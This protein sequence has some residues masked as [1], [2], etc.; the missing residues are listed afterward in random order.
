MKQ[1]IAILL[2]A[3]S[4]AGA[5]AQS[6]PNKPVRVVVAFTPGSST[7]IIGR[8]VAAKLQEMWGQP[9]VVENRAGAGG[10]VGSEFV[11]R[12][13]A[14]RLHAA[15]Q[16]V[17]ARGEPGHLQGHAL[18]HAE[19]LRQPGAARRRAER[20]DRRPGIGLEDA[21]RLRQRGEGQARQAQF[22]LGRRRQRH[23]FQPREAEDRDRHRRGRTCRT[24]ARPRRSATPSPTA[25]AATGRRST[26]R[27]RTSTAARRWRWRS[28]RR[29]A[30]RCCRTCRASRS[31][32]MPGFDYTLWVGL[33][34]PAKMPADVAAKIN[35]DVNARARQPGP[36]RAPDQARHRAGQPDDSP[37][38]RVREE[39]NRRD[40]PRSC[41][42]PESSPNERKDHETLLRILLAACAL[43]AA[44]PGLSEQAGAA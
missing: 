20:A 31:R 21:A 13:D 37:V 35:K 36:A 3:F 28:R 39:G 4:R 15:R 6:F 43:P 1:L 24:R 34:G 17:G 40:Q 9:V 29:S 14:G 5:L 26:P 25:C 8:A 32:A 44:R 41:R 18:R 27:C 2:A 19:R 11:L 42:P 7:D 30:R 12:S 23:A 22:R 16:F 38:H 33:W 10:T